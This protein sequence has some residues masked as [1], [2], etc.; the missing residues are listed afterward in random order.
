MRS[1]K[2]PRPLDFESAPAT[3]PAAERD[4]LTIQTVGFR[5]LDP[6]QETTSRAAARAPDELELE[7]EEVALQT[8]LEP[9]AGWPIWLAAVA[10]AGLWMLAPLAF[11]LGYR[12][13]LAPL[14]E[15]VFGL[16]VFTL[17]GAGPAALVLL[18]AFLIRQGQKLAHEARRTQ[19]LSDDMLAPAL[20]AASRA[21]GVA[22]DVREEI[23]RAASAA[24][25]ARLA[26]EAL[27][28]ALTLETEKLTGATAQSVRTANELAATLGRERSEMNQMSQALDVQALRVADAVAQQAKMVSEAVGVAEGQ[29]RES[30]ATLAART[31]DLAAAASE[32][33][34][35]SR[36]AGEDL[37]RHVAR[38]ET[39][40]G[41]VADQVRLAEAGLAAQR[42]AL[43]ALAETL[44][45]DQAAVT[46]AS[47]LQ[48]QRLKA[49]V[50]EVRALTGEI[51][52]QAAEGGATLRAT[53]AE[54]V[55]RFGSMTEEARNE[56]EAL[57]EA[58]E[59]SLD[60]LSRQ[61]T[62]HRA[63]LEMQTQAAAAALTSAAEAARAAADRHA[64]AAREHVDQLS[65]AAFGAG[66]TANRVFEARLEEAQALVSQSSKLLEETSAAT[67][68]RLGESAAQ[69]RA[70]AEELSA[71][72]AD[73][74]AR[75][76]RL[77]AAAADQAD[78]VRA[79][80]ARGLEA[81]SEQAQRA[82]LEAEAVDAAF[83]ARVR[84]HVDVLSEA[85]RVMR[86]S[87]PTATMEPPAP[88]VSEGP[89]AQADRLGL[90]ERIRLTPTATDREFSAL[91]AAASGRIATTPTLPDEDEP[92]DGEPWTWKDLLA[93]LDEPDDQGVSLETRVLADL[94]AM[95]IDPTSA[96]PDQ[97]LGGIG[98]ALIL[99][100][101]EAARAEVRGVAGPAVRRAAR[102]LFTDDE[103]RARAQIFV[104]RY[105]ALVADPARRPGSQPEMAELLADRGGR[106]F[107][108][109]DTAGG[110]ML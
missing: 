88:T 67:A 100:D 73:I 77:P 89:G 68:S 3:E 99:G 65:E 90:R 18:A 44:R 69:A 23:L 83:Q 76:A 75:A 14:T 105:Q 64:E 86:S 20:I 61:A 98:Q 39:A 6:R 1:S 60:R 29:I 79:A 13:R 30:E 52:A 22:Q 37:T 48:A 40:G 106:A 62:D 46:E 15:D 109:L 36:V 72:M 101:P 19:S 10:V 49:F 17:M 103:V 54:A 42:S 12:A 38:L 43:A 74:E 107:L 47:D 80:V 51:S 81:L 71:V 28:D 85:L 110:D 66:Q 104:R 108:L 92:T 50:D 96:I 82:T 41:G 59:R 16:A 55:V 93:S 8:V 25:E 78:Q 53:V 63:E 58:A 9:P 102:R 7:S 95:D 2:R 57:G 87:Q 56:R 4:A 97:A 21:G 84:Q 27:R 33:S 26:L 91:F 34:L 70:A 11:A 24:D 35:A 45:S 94:A 32:V 5:P 31:A